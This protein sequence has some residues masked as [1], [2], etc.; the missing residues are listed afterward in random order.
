[1]GLLAAGKKR[2]FCVSELMY[3]VV[4][5]FLNRNDHIVAA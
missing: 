3:R 1:M 2:N 4:D 5:G